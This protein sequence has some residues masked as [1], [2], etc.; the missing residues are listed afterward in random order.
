MKKHITKRILIILMSLVFVFSTTAC[1]QLNLVEDEVSSDAV[2]TSENEVATEESNEVSDDSATGTDTSETT[3]MITDV[4][5]SGNEVTE[6]QEYIPDEQESSNPA[7]GETQEEETQ[8]SETTTAATSPRIESGTPV[9]NHGELSV[10][11]TNLVDKNGNP[12]QI[13]GVSTHGLSW[14][15]EYVNKE[16]FRT[17][18]DEWGANCIRL[19]MYSAEYNGYCTGGN[20]SQLKQT[21][22]NG[23]SYATELGMYVIIDW[24]VLGDQDPNVYKSQAIAFFREMS[25]KYADYDNVIYEICNEPNG[26]VNWASVKSYAEEVIPVIKANNPDA[27]IIVGTPTWSQDVD[28]AAANPITGYSNIMYTLHFYAD[29]HRDSLRQKMISA[30]NSGIPIFC[31]EFGICDASGNGANNISEGNAWIAAMDANNISYCIWNLSNKA[32]SSSL[33]SSGCNR[34]SGW[35]MNDLSE[36]GRWYVGILNN[37]VEPGSTASGD[38]SSSGNSGNNSG[39]NSGSN[40]GGNSGGSTAVTATAANTQATIV[41]SGNWSSGNSNCYQFTVTI[42]NTGSSAVKDWKITINMGS[43]VSL[44]QSWSGNFSVNGSNLVV[45]PMDFNSEIAA[46]QS[47]EVGFIVSTQGSLGTPSITVN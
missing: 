33:I 21:V 2:I 9:G 17:I 43:N 24:H 13:R 46:G 31:T 20:Q 22:N 38:T 36:S 23:V 30:L 16:A 10:Q 15:P 7:T 8:E 26:G 45:T 14:F 3:V 41:S 37:G 6:T 42:K 32:E 34:T 39:N 5:E 12:F 1:G 25:E 44:D 27:I 47:V 28:Q 40:S 4:S 35:T 11:G 29:T 19:A 18:R